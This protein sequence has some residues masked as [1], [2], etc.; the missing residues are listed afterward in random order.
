MGYNVLVWWYYSLHPKHNVSQSLIGM[1]TNSRQWVAWRFVSLPHVTTDTFG[2]SCCVTATDYLL[3]VD[4]ESDQ[5]TDRLEG[6]TSFGLYD[7][8]GIWD[9]P[10]SNK[11]KGI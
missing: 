4:V 10:C 1:E 11:L 5:S 7:D 8:L 9:L 2:G 3:A 6:T